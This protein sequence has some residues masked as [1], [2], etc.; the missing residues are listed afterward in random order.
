MGFSFRKTFRFGPLK[1]N[2]STRGL[3]MSAGVRGARVSVGPRGTYVTIGRGGFVYRQRLTSNRSRSLASKTTTSP[4]GSG[5]VV[6]TPVPATVAC[7]SG[8]LWSASAEQLSASSPDAALQDIINRRQRFD[9]FTLYAVAA[10]VT[11]GAAG[12]ATLVGLSAA[13]PQLSVVHFLLVAFVVGLSVGLLVLGIVVFAWSTERRTA[14]LLYD[15]DDERLLLRMNQCNTVGLALSQTGRLWHIYHAIGTDDWKRNAG[16]S[17]LIRRTV[18]QCVT[19]ML[20]HI[21]TNIE[22][23]GIL[24]GPQRLLFLPDRLLV[25]EGKAMAAVP[26]EN[27]IVEVSQKRFIEEDVRPPD[28]PV[29]DWT[30]RYVNRSGG[31]DMRFNNNI[32][33]PVMGY[34][35]LALSSFGGLRVVLQTSNCD[36]ASRAAQALAGLKQGPI[37]SS[38]TF[39]AVPAASQYQ[40]SQHPLPPGS[41]IP[42]PIL[43]PS[44]VSGTPIGTSHSLLRDAAVLLRYIAVA[45]RRIS[46]DEVAEVSRFLASLVPG[47]PTAV[48]SVM[49]D[50]RKMES[51]DLNAAETAR[52]LRDA[53]P[54]ALRW[55]L[56]CAARIAAADGRVTPKE[57]ERMEVLK[58]LAEGRL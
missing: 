29:L 26:Y 27:L 46:D 11:W 31:P 52:R 23:W 2:L 1:L 36:A 18:I 5:N 41:A 4:W 35:E 16:A 47:D 56:G 57:S 33:L 22:V 51:S 17:T 24:V 58:R 50:F 53:H 15:V 40:V 20:P 10:V 14:R 8:N 55:I 6:P 34:G 48:S 9:W 25:S 49:G 12:I 45:D 43:N 42:T 28:A 7:E 21:E 37:D 54:D 3:G 19:G 13:G 30:W 39:P 44:R 32:Q 38:E